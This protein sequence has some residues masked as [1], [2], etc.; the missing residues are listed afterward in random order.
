MAQ[1]NAL[2]KYSELQSDFVFQS[3]NNFNTLLPTPM[4]EIAWD[5]TLHRPKIKF[6]ENDL[7]VNLQFNGSIYWPT[8][9][10][11]SE[12]NCMNDSSPPC[13]LADY[14]AIV[15]NS[16]EELFLYPVGSPTYAYGNSTSISL[17][18]DGRNV[19]IPDLTIKKEGNNDDLLKINFA[20]KYTGVTGNADS[21]LS[22]MCA[23]DYLSTG[24][25]ED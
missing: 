13:A 8:A 14:Q 19:T 4:I 6:L 9:F 17:L 23:Y 20:I 3:F 11:S 5:S 16:G 22:Y 1:I 10:G 15:K 18:Q 2:Y 25:L 12:I 24:I 7:R 21:V